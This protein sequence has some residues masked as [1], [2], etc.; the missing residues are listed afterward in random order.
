VSVGGEEGDV[1]VVSVVAVV[2]LVSVAGGGTCLFLGIGVVLPAVSVV[3]GGP[4]VS[5]PSGFGLSGSVRFVVVWAFVSVAGAVVSPGAL[6][7]EVTPLAEPSC[8]T[9]YCC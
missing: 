1:V 6:I 5:L 8:T 2:A 3:T 9:S 4:P 7:V